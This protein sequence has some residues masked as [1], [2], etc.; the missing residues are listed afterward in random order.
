MMN[1]TDSEL[2]KPKESTGIWIKHQQI[3][4]LEN[5]LDANCFVT[6]YFTTFSSCDHGL[7]L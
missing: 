6:V 1:Y 2:L 5:E 7:G 4:T 3:R